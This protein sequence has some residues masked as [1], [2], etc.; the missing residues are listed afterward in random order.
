MAHARI[1]DGTNTLEFRQAQTDEDQREAVADITAELGVDRPP[2]VHVRSRERTRTVEGRV[3]APSAARD[4]ATTDN[5]RTALA[6]YVARL[7]AFCT[8]HQGLGYTFEDDLRDKQFPVVYHRLAWRLSGGQPYEVQFELELATGEGVLPGQPLTIPN[9]SPDTSLPTAARVDGVDLPGLRQL[10]VER[11]FEYEVDPLYDKSTASN[12]QVRATSGVQH[13][14]QFQ[15]THTGDRTTRRQA[16]DELQALIGAGELDFE[17][18]FPGYTKTGK[19]LNYET[20]DEA[21]FA[22][23]QHHYTLSFLEAINA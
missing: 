20:T 5:W 7:E 15:G 2:L 4:D 22:D 16:D 8:D 21:G 19:V 10:S 12:N 11:A 3:T 13:R 1:T 23:N 6:R 9:V 18:R 17:T 14:I